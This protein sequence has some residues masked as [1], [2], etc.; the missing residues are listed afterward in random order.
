[1]SHGGFSWFANAMDPFDPSAQSTGGVVA[2]QPSVAAPSPNVLDPNEQ[3]GPSPPTPRSVPEEIIRDVMRGVL[4]GKDLV[5]ISL[6]EVRRSLSAKLGFAPEALDPRKKELKHIAKT[7]VEELRVKVASKLLLDA[8]LV[9]PESNIVQTVYLITMARVLASTLADGAN[10]KDLNVVERKTIAEAVLD[11]FNNPVASTCGGR[12]RTSGSIN[13]VELIV[14][15]RESHED[16]SIHFHIAV[17]LRRGQHF[18][19]AKKT[20]QVRHSMP[21]HFSCSHTQLWSAIRYGHIE[22]PA[23]PQV[24]ETPWI[25]TPTWTGFAHE[26]EVVDLFELSQ[27]PWNADVWRKRRVAQNKEAS[28][29]NAK[30]KFEQLDLTSIIMSKHLYTKDSLLAYAQTS[31]THAMMRF[32]HNR[33]DKLTQ[34]IE[35]AKEWGSAKDNAA[36]DAIDDWT[37]LCNEATKPCPHRGC[38]CG[39]KIAS[40]QVFERNAGTLDELRLAFALRAILINGPK[41]TVR[42][43]FLQGPSNSGKSTLLYPFDDLFEPKRVLHKPALGSTFGLRN[44]ATGKKRLIFWDDYSP[45]E[46]AA[47][48][49]VPASLFLSLFIGKFAEIAASGSFNDGNMD[50]CWNHGVVF[51]GRHEGLWTPNKRV[52]AEEVRH[53]RNRVEE[54]LIMVPMEIGALKDVTSCSVHM[55]QWIVDGANKYDAREGLR[56]V[57]APAAAVSQCAGIVPTIVGLQELLAH[58]QLDEATSDAF[59]KELAAIGTTDVVELQ[60]GDWESL[61][62]LT[63]FKLLQ[64]RRLFAHVKAF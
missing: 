16:G 50:V 2:P 32:V 43:P 10:F 64:R 30:T 9:Q 62:V 13:V 46:Y 60:A 17:K 57:L 34:D 6:G 1:M 35:R 19:S 20:L 48:K 40:R 7:I 22:T 33:Q 28:Q 26:Q 12:P 49:T 54:F 44:I 39:Y 38:E 47:E 23:K 24:D 5:T 3:A 52:S 51:T 27:Q 45:I 37:L 14:V 4:V 29:K 25:W 58:V 56:G 63:Q 41:K 8:L 59:C 15:Y 18:A 61:E 53:I 55:A 42:V 21:S 36:F 11:A 31:G